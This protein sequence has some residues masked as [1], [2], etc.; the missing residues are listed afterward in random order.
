MKTQKILGQV[1]LLILIFLVSATRVVAEQNLQTVLENL[2]SKDLYTRMEA[3]REISDISG[4]GD[5]LG[6]PTADYFQIK[7]KYK[8]DARVKKALFKLADT[9]L[10]ESK[11]LH[12]RLREEQREGYGDYKHALFSTIGNMRELE[13]VPY[14]FSY[15]TPDILKKVADVGEMV[16]P[17]VLNKLYHG[18]GALDEYAATVVLASLLKKEPHLKKYSLKS[19]QEIKKALIYVA[20]E[21]NDMDA[22]RVAV[23]GFKE[24][25]V[26][27][28]A[29]TLRMVEK[30]TGDNRTYVIS[31]VPGGDK[32]TYPVREEAQKVLGELKAKG[33]YKPKLQSDTTQQ[34]KIQ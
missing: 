31:G 9:E 4:W 3:F 28:D 13:G 30:L 34:N 21:T 18:K 7:T 12:L 11:Q 1:G 23:Y 26:Q 2:Q 32:T 6:T 14:L 25:A 19:K 8:M 33:I 20:N 17:Q 10:K 15:G 27:G 16:L 22:T 24:L 29:E 5:S